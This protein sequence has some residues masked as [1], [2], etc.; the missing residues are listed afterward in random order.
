MTAT[1][2]RLSFA[3]GGTDIADFYR[4]EEGAVVSTAIDKFVYVVVKTHG[5]LYDES[6]RLNYFDTEHA[7]QLSEIKNDIIR[8]SLRLI[9]VDPP[10]YIS[11]V[12]DVPSSSGLGSS[13]AF[14]VGLLNAL[15]VLRGDRV[16]MGQLAEEACH[17]EIEVLKNP[18]G[19][20]DQYAAAFG[21]M[22][23]MRFEK[24]G[25]VLV[26]PQVMSA[27]RVRTLFD[28]LMLFWT[29]SPRSA[30]EVLTKQRD[31]VEARMDNLRSIKG[32]CEAVRDLFQTGVDPRRLGDIL[33]ETWR[34]KRGIS[35]AVSNS[36]IDT[37]YA[38]AIDSGAIGGKIA[39]AGGGGFLML[40]V[41]PD[42]QMSVASALSDLQCLPFQYE[43]S[44][45]RVLIPSWQ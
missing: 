2:L 1:P 4:K 42:R 6:Y 9:D 28:H 21:G 27:E 17:I 39:G 18:I 38:R 11:T 44:G 10:I 33:D 3:G 13:S 16:S 40:V 32:H 41:P 15:H 35:E 8:E 20:Q 30:S 31:N 5:E 36:Q 29:N 22:N 34:Q 23:Y 24:D 25:R 14:A 37:W 7:H 45:T 12:A 26:E 19:K 43:A